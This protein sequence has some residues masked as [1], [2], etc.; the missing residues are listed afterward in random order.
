HPGQREFLLHPAKFKVLACGRRWGK[1]DACAVQVL[2]ALHRPFPTKHLILAPTADQ[3][4]LLFER[5][6]GLL[7]RPSGRSDGSDESDGSE[8]SDKSDWKLKHSP[9]PRLRFGAHTVMARSGHL[10]RALRGHEA[11]HIVVDE[12]AYLPES[13]VT[14]VAMPML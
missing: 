4:S 8:K 1:T 10:P 7:G 3:A 13:L 9:Y 14:E 11:T 6:V 5:V 12:A 2:Q